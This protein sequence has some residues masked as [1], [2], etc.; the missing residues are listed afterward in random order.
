MND[1]WLFALFDAG[2]LRRA[3]HKLKLSPAKTVTRLP[4]GRH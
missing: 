2:W 1:L 3:E 4:A